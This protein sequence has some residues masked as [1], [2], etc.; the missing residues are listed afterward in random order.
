MATGPGAKKLRPHKST[1]RP[2]MTGYD[3]FKQSFPRAMTINEKAT[4]T[5]VRGK[6]GR[7][8]SGRRR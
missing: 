5:D 1:G 3:T 8:I 7:S 2:P 6:S 4:T